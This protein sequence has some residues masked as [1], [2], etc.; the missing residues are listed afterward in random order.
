MKLTLKTYK[1]DYLES[2]VDVYF[3]SC[4]HWDAQRMAQVYA[5]K[6]GLTLNAVWLEAHELAM[7]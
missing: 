1:A 3:E 5:D 6:H 2:P 7:R 4:T